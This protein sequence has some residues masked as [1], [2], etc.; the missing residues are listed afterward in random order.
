MF[1]FLC[2]YMSIVY[3]VCV[4]VRDTRAHVCVCV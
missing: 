4:F 3:E 1:Y 2:V